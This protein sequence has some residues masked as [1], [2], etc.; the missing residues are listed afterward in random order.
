SNDRIQGKIKD[1]SDMKVPYCAVVGPRDA[2]G[3]KVSVRAFGIE[4]NLGEVGFDAFV[5][6]LVR[7]YRSRGAETVRSKLGE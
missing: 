1:A 6:G 7:E 4:A 3:H 2:E 5:D